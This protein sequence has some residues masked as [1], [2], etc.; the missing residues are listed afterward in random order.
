MQGNPDA[1]SFIKSFTGSHR[2]V[3]DYLL[4]EVLQRQP[5]EI[6]TFLLRTSILDH[7]CGPL[8][9]AVL[10]DPSVSGQETLEYLEHA[11]LFLVSLDNERHWY[12]YHHLFADLLRQR[13]LQQPRTLRNSPLSGGK[14]NGGTA[15]RLDANM[16]HRRAS[17][18]Y[19]HNGLAADA[20]RHALAAQ[21]FERAA[22]LIELAVPGIR[23]KSAR[24]HPYGA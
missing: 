23:R 19:E 6:Q 11:N 20:I 17:E 4:E 8:C 10:L 15:E 2:F 3:L 12:R 24:N 21:D 1:G 14:E 9:D 22:T 5:A 16:L 18:W 7:L 13:L